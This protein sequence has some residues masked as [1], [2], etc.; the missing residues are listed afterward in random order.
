MAARTTA[1]LTALLSA[2]RDEPAE[3]VRARSS[4]VT[5]STATRPAAFAAS[6]RRTVSPSVW[7]GTTTVIWASGSPSFEARI[8][9]AS[10]AVAG[11]PYLALRI[12]VA[13]GRQT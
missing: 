9:S 12:F 11:R 3:S 1:S 8:T 5:K 7:L 13:I 10:V 6:C 4:R 2:S